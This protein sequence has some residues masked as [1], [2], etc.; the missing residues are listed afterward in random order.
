MAKKRRKV[1]YSRVNPAKPNLVLREVDYIVGRAAEM[2]SRVVTL[3][4]VA[5]LLDGDR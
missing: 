4:Q 3:G 2:E 1:K 5:V